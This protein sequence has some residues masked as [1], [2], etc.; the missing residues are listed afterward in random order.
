MR[1]GGS[2]G[3]SMARNAM[4]DDTPLNRDGRITTLLPELPNSCYRLQTKFGG[5]SCFSQVSV[6]PQGDLCMMPL[7][8]WLP[9]HMFLLRGSLYLVACSFEG[10]GSL[11]R[12]S[13]SGR[14][15]LDRDPP[16]R[17]RAG[18]MHPTGMHSCITGYSFIVLLWKHT[19]WMDILFYIFFCKCLWLHW[20]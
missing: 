20:N 14:P 3:K 13:L 1:A 8:V 11:S 17:L 9:G 7:P 5:R 12:G 4:G 2:N 16:V 19:E 15:T 18:G 10:G 6:C